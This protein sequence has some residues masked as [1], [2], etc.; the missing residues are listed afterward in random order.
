MART[1]SAGISHMDETNWTVRIIP[2]GMIPAPTGL[3]V[4]I[5]TR[6]SWS[7]SFISRT[8]SYIVR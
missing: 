4:P 3:S 2:M 6:W 1:F 7:R 5:S 8:K